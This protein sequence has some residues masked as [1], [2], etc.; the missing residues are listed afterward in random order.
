[1]ISGK[2]NS[3]KIW[4]EN[5][6]GLSTLPVTCS[7]FTL[8]NPKSRFLSLAAAALLSVELILIVFYVNKYITIKYCRDYYYTTAIRPPLTVSSAQS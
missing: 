2:L 4:H 1:M 3:D 8:G 5:L 7:H 6:T